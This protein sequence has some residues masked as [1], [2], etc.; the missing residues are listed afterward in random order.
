MS[1]LKRTDNFDFVLLLAWT[2]QTKQ[3]ALRHVSY[4]QKAIRLFIRR[5]KVYRCLINSI[6]YIRIMW[7]LWPMQ[8]LLLFSLCYA[9][10]FRK[11]LSFHVFTVMRRGSVCWVLAMKI[12]FFVYSNLLSSSPLVWSWALASGL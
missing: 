8:V 2:L 5:Y 10:I 6:T 1:H 11:S 9:A 12:V 4:L 7:A 3:T